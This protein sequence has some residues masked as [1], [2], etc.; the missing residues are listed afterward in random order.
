M[1]SKIHICQIRHCN[2]VDCP[3]KRGQLVRL[4][5]C[6]CRK[7]NKDVAWIKKPIRQNQGK[8]WRKGNCCTRRRTKIGKKTETRADPSQQ[9][10]WYG[11]CLFTQC[12]ERVFM[13][14]AGWKAPQTAKASKFKDCIILKLPERCSSEGEK[15]GWKSLRWQPAKG[16]DTLFKGFRC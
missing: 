6:S 3:L 2:M 7:A 12:G 5:G 10:R 9:P 16:T 4:R 11:F 1:R 13:T 15:P 8:V 14:G